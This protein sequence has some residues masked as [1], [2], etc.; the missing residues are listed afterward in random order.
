MSDSDSKTLRFIQAKW[1]EKES[2]QRLQFQRYQKVNDIFR[3]ASD[4]DN[5]TRRIG[6]SYNTALKI[7][8]QNIK[9]SYSTKGLRNINQEEAEVIKVFL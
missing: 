9:K 5:F 6:A 8:L 4:K 7:I 3:K 1:A 2:D